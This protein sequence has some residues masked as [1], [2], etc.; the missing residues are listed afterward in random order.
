[1]NGNSYVL[2]T[3]AVIQLLRGNQEVI[4]IASSA[5]FLA[6]SVITELEFLSYSRLSNN[7]VQLFER[8]KSRVEVVSLESSNTE[9]MQT[10]CNLRL[11]TSLNM[12]DAIVAA[13]ALARNA[14]LITA[15]VKCLNFLGENSLSFVF[16]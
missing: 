16:I 3:N 4:K 7:D 15:D 11:N 10:V 12:P 5:D 13:T 1:M 9:L 2:D 6:V 8:F 14:Q